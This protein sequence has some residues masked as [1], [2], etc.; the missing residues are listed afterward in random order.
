MKLVATVFNCL[1]YT[2]ISTFR[3]TYILSTY[4]WELNFITVNLQVVDLDEEL[5]EFFK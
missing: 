4:Y 2:H 5:R 1:I 3:T